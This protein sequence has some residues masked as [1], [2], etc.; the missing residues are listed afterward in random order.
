MSTDIQTPAGADGIL[1]GSAAWVGDQLDPQAGMVSIDDDCLTELI[2]LAA[3]LEANPVPVLTLDPDDFDL[4]ACRALMG[5]VKET[6]DTGVGFALIDRLPVEDLGRE[7]AIALYWL[8]GNMTGRAVAQK[9][10]GTMFYEVRDTGRVPMPGNGIRSSV[11]NR[12]QEF[13]TDNSYNLPPD[14]VALLCLHPAK[15]GGVSGIVS[16]QTAHNRMAELHPD[17]LQ[18]LYRPYWFDRQY[19]HAPDDS[20]KVRKFP[21]FAHDGELLRTRYA[22][23]LMN[24]GHKLMDEP[25]DEVGREAM[26]ALDRIIEEPV[27]CREFDFKSGQIQILDNRRIG[28]RRTGFEDWPDE[29]RRRHLIRLWFRNQ[30]RPFYS[31]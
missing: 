1:E 10:D 12:R 8:L 4:P 21:V 23:S 13:H 17:L 14:Y 28:H 20:E 30:G 16:F 6:L 22:I 25:L 31:G 7:R 24:G 9:W 26:E 2:D 15:E 18:R 29:E 19:E 11:S 27:M 5:R 3:V